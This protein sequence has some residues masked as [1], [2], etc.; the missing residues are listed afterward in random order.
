MKIVF[1]GLL[2]QVPCSLVLVTYRGHWNWGLVVWDK[3]F[4]A[5]ATALQETEFGDSAT[6]GEFEG[7]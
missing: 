6:E 1:Q 4:A 7:T 2:C 5:G 3:E